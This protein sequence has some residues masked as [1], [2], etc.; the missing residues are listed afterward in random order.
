MGG[1]FPV[2]SK[3]FATDDQKLGNQISALYA[4]NTAGGVLGVFLTG[5]IFISMLGVRASYYIAVG[6]NIL[7]AILALH[8]SRLRWVA[9]PKQKTDVKTFLPEHLNQTTLYSKNKTKLSVLIFAVSGFTSLA[10]EVVFT[11]ALL[12]YISST[13][14]SFTIMLAT[15]LLGIMLGSMLLSRYIHRLRNLFFAFGLAEL[16]IGI[17]SVMTIMLFKH[18]DSYH[19]RLL[20]S[21]ISSNFFHV[22]LLLFATAALILL[23]PTFAM[24]TAFFICAIP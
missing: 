18:M 23:P 22:N 6:I 21:L 8:L 20:S 3:L 12:F 19:L 15:F 11:R 13:T 14:Y 2:I 5:Y 9:A 4:V 1:T 16:T 10:Y 24:G 17:T 7:V